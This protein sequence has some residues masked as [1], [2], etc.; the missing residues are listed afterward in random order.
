MD[1]TQSIGNTNEMQCM[2]AFMQL[3]YNCS[4]PFGNSAKYDFI[5]D[6]NNKLLRIQCKSSR[7]T[8]NHGKISKD[9]FTFDTTCATINT[10]ESKRYTYTKNQIDYFATCFDG[11]VYIIPVDECS[12]AKT[13][14]F[15]PPN[16][17]NTVYNKAEDYLIT[18]YFQE[19]DQY[20]KSKENYLNR[21]AQS[22][23]SK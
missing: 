17:G 12:T 1:Y 7:Y 20:K 18:N 2:L 10:K 8:N 15:T 14:R 11:K 13:L 23:Y 16:N 19:S 6:V 21:Y 5:V 22:N 3:G 9:S 4:I